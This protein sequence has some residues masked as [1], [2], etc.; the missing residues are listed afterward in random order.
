MAG[1]WS[2]PQGSLGSE[3]CPPLPSPPPPV[4]PTPPAGRTPNPCLGDNNR[5]HPH[6]HLLVLRKKCPTSPPANAFP[7]FKHPL[8][9]EQQPLSPSPPHPDVTVV[10][11]QPRVSASPTP[12]PSLSRSSDVGQGCTVEGATAWLRV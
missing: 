10:R 2:Y 3:W 6:L 12:S 7:N 11:W 1:L 8:M 5:V 9:L 4:L